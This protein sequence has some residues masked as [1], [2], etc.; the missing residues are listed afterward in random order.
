MASVTSAF[1][2]AL[3]RAAG[4][5]VRPDGCVSAHDDVVYRL[6]APLDQSIP[7]A[8]YFDLIEWISTRCDDATGLVFRYASEIET[9][10]IGALGLAAKS[11]PV[12]GDTLRRLERYFRLVTD[13]AAYRLVE[14]GD[15]A[16]FIFEGFT[17][18]RRA[19]PLRNE[20]ALAA[21]ARNIKAFGGPALSFDLVSFKHSCRDDPARFAAFFE[22][23]VRFDADMNAIVLHRDMLCLPNRLGDRG[24]SDFLTQHL[25]T[26]IARLSDRSP[27]KEEVLRHISNSLSTGVPLATDIARQMGMS[28]RTLYRRLSDENL[29]FRN[30]VQDAQS[31]L[32]RELL[33]ETSCSISEIAFLTGFSEQSAFSRA[34]KRWV[35]EAPAR[36]RQ[37]S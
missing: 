4:L 37:L 8:S 23:D 28:E 26:E 11:A 10:D 24:I 13:T 30:V 21:V 36:F 6:P 16:L 32:A 27:L 35:G 20:C 15:Q 9:D 29:S 17:E 19:L 5:A 34:F 33:S 31:A 1:A 7:D 2:T 25:D 22:C 18:E 14:T 12:L 3:A